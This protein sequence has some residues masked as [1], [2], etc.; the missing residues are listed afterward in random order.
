MV[1]SLDGNQMKWQTRHC[2]GES[3]G[4]KHRD[5]LGTERNVPAWLSR[6]DY[7]RIMPRVV[8]HQ[9]WMSC[10]KNKGA[11][12]ICMGVCWVHMGTHY[13]PN[14]HYNH[15]EG[16]H[17]NPSGIG[18]CIREHACLDNWDNGTCRDD[19]VRRKQ[20]IWSAYIQCKT[21][22]FFFQQNHQSKNRYSLSLSLFSFSLTLFFSFS[23]TKGTPGSS[24]RVLVLVW[25]IK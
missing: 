15:K 18:I 17:R 19:L 20:C 4:R 12:S 13:S 21:L 10:V 9:T 8:L 24:N 22:D 5:E 6:I 25:N 14:P 11:A 7:S 3:G 1:M 2:W 23:I 16:H